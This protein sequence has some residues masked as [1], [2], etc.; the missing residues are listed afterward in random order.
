[1]TMSIVVA[2]ECHDNTVRPAHDGS[3]LGASGRKVREPHA[4][5]IGL[6]QSPRTI[7]IST[8]AAT[9]PLIANTWEAYR[10]PQLKRIFIQPAAS[11]V[12]KIDLLYRL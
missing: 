1:M 10:S 6:S 3:S 8:R 2:G 5:E 7:V 12:Y 4:A 11:I 9:R